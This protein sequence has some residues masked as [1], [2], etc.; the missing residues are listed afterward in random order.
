MLSCSEICGMTCPVNEAFQFEYL[1]LK[2]LIEILGVHRKTSNDA[3]RAEFK[4]LPLRG[5][6]L[7]LYANSLVSSNKVLQ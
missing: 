3:C 4:R 6:I 2:V 5:N 7:N 1:H